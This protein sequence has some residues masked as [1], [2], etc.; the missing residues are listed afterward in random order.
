MWHRRFLNSVPT[1]WHWSPRSVPKQLCGL[2]VSLGVSEAQFLQPS[3]DV[4][5]IPGVS[6]VLDKMKCRSRPLTLL[7]PHR[8]RLSSK[9][10]VMLAP[11]GLGACRCLGRAAFTRADSIS[12][13][14][15][16]LCPNVTFSAKPRLTTSFEI[17]NGN[18]TL[19]SL[20]RFYYFFLH[21]TSRFL[22][23]M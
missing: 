17:V 2:G 10:T 4:A 22:D 12:L 13:S 14:S 3:K 7:Q 18:C 20:F 19:Q 5:Q 23:S 6:S 1:G 16:D 11:Q 15:S 8:P 9:M 21:S